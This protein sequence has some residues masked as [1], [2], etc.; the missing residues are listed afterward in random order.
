V[1]NLIE[2]VEGIILS[3]TPYR[4]TSKIIQVYTKEHGLISMIAKGAKSLKSNLR[5]GT[6]LYTYGYFYIYYKKDKLSQLT[7]VDI[8]DSFI[9][10]RTDIKLISYMAYLCDLTKQVLRE[11][12]NLKM[13]PMLIDAIK[14]I[15]NKLDPLIITN[16]IEIKYLDYLGIG[17]NLD[18]CIKCG[19]TKGIVTIDPDLGGFVCQNCYQDEYIVNPKTIKLIRMYYYVDIKSIT[20]IK[21]SDKVKQ[22]IN[23][24]LTRYYDRYTGLYLKSKEFLNRI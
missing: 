10:I 3:E 6:I 19:S 9:N 12:N 20:E 14:K 11:N 24:F 1:I 22:E 18:E 4:E 17:L 5:A 7:N 23:M 13:F 21:V 16:I 15:D 8:I 2:K